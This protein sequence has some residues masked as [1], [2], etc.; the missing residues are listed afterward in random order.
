MHAVRHL[1]LLDIVLILLLEL[2][3]GNLDGLSKL[4]DVQK[5]VPHRAALRHLVF[6]LVFLVLR[7]DLRLRRR[8]L[9]F[10]ILWLDECV[11]EFYLF[12]FVA[13]SILEFPG[14]NA[15]PIG[16]EF[17]EFFLEES[18]A[19]E[20]LKDRYSQLKSLL[21]QGGVLVQSDKGTAIESHREIQANAVCAFLIG[22]R[23]SQ[24]L[25]LILDL[26]LKNELLQNLLRVK[27]FQLLGH[28]I[29]AL[30]LVELFADVLYGHRLIPDFGDGVRRDLTGGG[31]LRHKVQ[32]HAPAQNQDCRAQEDAF[33]QFAS[34][35]FA[36]GHLLISQVPR[37]T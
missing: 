8:D 11:V 25:G 17:P 34:V 29:T 6:R 22:N 23:D 30:N 4:V 21:D 24:A 37:Q 16:Y 35:F 14:P 26:S 3:V 27:T 28:L 31:P 9:R 1:I 20:V 33:S 18:L 19:N 13:V 5:R 32:Q 12:V 36:A 2:I 7:L 15:D 10:Q